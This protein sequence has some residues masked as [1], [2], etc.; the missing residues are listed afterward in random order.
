MSS[1]VGSVVPDERT[2]VGDPDET[3]DGIVVLYGSSASWAP[4]TSGGPVPPGA[5]LGPDER[6]NLLDW[7]TIVGDWVRATVWLVSHLGPE[8][9]GLAVED[10]TRSAVLT[11]R[12]V[13][14]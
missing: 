11:V 1:A 5:R 2:Q 9:F 8:P 12:G 4:W 13:G 6:G 14:R 10:A 3:G 7:D